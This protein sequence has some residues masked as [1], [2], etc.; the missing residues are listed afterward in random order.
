MTTTTIKPLR[1]RLPDGGVTLNFH[2]GQ[3]RAWHSKARFVFML[4]SPQ[5]GKT[6]FGPHWLHREIG[7][8]GGGDYL[9]VTATYDMFKLKML[10]EL[11]EVFVEISG[12]GKYWAGAKVI[13]IAED[14]KPGNFKAKHQDDKMWARI[15]LRSADAAVGLE[16]ATANAAW[17]DEP[18]HKD[19]RYSSW[20]A[21]DRRV[22]LS[23]GRILGTSTIYGVNWVKTEIYNPWRK[24]DKT[25]D[26]IQCDALMNPIFPK[27]EYER[28]KKRM[29]PWKFNMIYRGT[30]DTPAGLIYDS[31]DDA[32]CVV[33]RFPISKDWPRFVGHDFGG[34][35]PA[36]IFFAQDPGTG[37]F[38]GYHE[39]LPGSGRSTS[40]HVNE[41]KEITKDTSVIKRA[42]GSHQEDEIRQ[43]YT[44]H[45]WPIQEPKVNNVTAG[46][47]KVY[48]LHKLNKVFIFS[49]MENY[50]R[51]KLSYSYK[52]DDQFNPTEEIEDK[53]KFHLMDCL[54][55]G[56]LITTEVGLKPIENIMIGENVL[57]RQG[58]FPVL[59]TIRKSAETVSAH[60]SNGSVLKGTANHSVF[61][62]GKGFLPLDAL[63]YKDIIEVCQKSFVS[64]E[65]TTTVIL[66]PRDGQTGFI[67][68]I[69]G[70]IFTELFG[71]P[72][73]G[74]YLKG[75]LSIIKTLIPSIMNCLTWLSRLMVFICQTICGG[76][77]LILNTSLEYDFSLRRG[78]NQKRV[79]GGIVSTGK[80][81]QLIDSQF[82]KIVN[83]AE[84]SI[85]LFSL[86]VVN[87]VLTFARRDTA[88]QPDKIGKTANAQFATYG[89]P[90][91][92]ILE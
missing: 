19:F 89:L 85:K 41:F 61:V 15:I 33:P 91:I 26:V 84:K 46:I 1:E 69:R 32:S 68:K 45:G 52:L 70:N 73:S 2:Q 11:L 6:C 12:V 17:V 21:I 22:L 71:K 16:S 80:L 42:G 40:E 83:D 35:N 14:M 44:S 24:G 8:C 20:E 72:T 55:A 28:E 56:T 43:G 36:A 59:R 51:E 18:G 50:L 23:K 4:G 77:L 49:D 86:L 47:D 39:Y 74:K 64:T 90:S 31:F 63:R 10:R 62:K 34:S 25:I 60:F 37:F 29:P 78:T 79:E 76:N 65:L 13:E 9:A 27:E 75:I 38:Y 88:T 3:Q 54:V 30:Y 58:Y 82:L 53:S 81:Y 5:V 67:S 92:S 87:S 66:N 57:T 48:A 7:L